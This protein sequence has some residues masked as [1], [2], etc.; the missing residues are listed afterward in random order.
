MGLQ[1]SGSVQLEG[2][3]LVT[4]SANSVFE[5]ISVTNRITANEINV[6]FVSSSIIYSS[7]SNKFGD[8]SGDKHQFTGSVSITGSQTIYGKVGIDALSSYAKFNISTGNDNQMAIGTTSVGQ[9][10]GIFLADGPSTS[11]VGYKWE[12]GKSSDNDFFIYSY[13]TA[14]FP[15]KINYASGAATFS[16]TLDAKKGTFTDSFSL[17]NAQI[18]AI[19]NSATNVSYAGIRLVNSSSNGAYFTLGDTSTATWYGAQSAFMTLGGALGVGFKL[20]VDAD[21]AKGITIPTSGNVGIGTTSPTGKL[22]LYQS[23]AGNVF[24]NIVSNQGGSTQAG[25]NFSPSTTDVD[26]ASNPPQASIY[27]TD[28]NYGAN[29]IFANKLTGAIGN[30]LEERMRITSTGNVL[31]GKT[32]SAIDT[33]DGL[34]VDSDGTLFA[35]ITNGESSY[36]IRDITNAAY[37]FRVSG[38]GTVFATN[39]TISSISDIRLKEN[40]R[41]LESGLDKIMLLKPRLFDWKEGSG[42]TGKDIRGFIAQEVEEFFPE[43]IDEWGNENLQE[44]E[45]PYKSV[46][47]DVIPMIVKAIQELKTEIDSLKNQIK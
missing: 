6:Q 21:D 12:F 28:S 22:M 36:Y 44:D 20:R 11:S 38:T 19:S 10:S 46:R 45:T 14:G 32:D 25:I 18:N 24:L 9:T 17:G 13:G 33:G 1:L 47:M 8:E 29:I 34:R 27:A 37:R 15:F 5:N 7:G 35:C 39:T 31:I 42:Q 4:G 2:N 41:D 26:I 43:M 40:V 23:V 30:A 3:L 16:S